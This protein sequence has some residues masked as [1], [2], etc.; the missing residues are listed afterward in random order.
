MSTA[1]A[2]VYSYSSSSSSSSVSRY[3]NIDG[4]IHSESE[5]SES[6][7]E[8]DS[9]GLD[10]HGSGTIK[11]SDGSQIFET[12]ENCNNGDCISRVDKRLRKLIPI[13]RV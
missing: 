4:K 5:S 7:S 1:D 9:S 12:T 2:Q 10:R 3:S 6:Y 11:E 13:Y 8:N